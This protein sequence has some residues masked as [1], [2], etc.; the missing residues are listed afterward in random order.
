MHLNDRATPDLA[1]KK[2]YT[3][4]IDLIVDSITLTK[5]EIENGEVKTKLLCEYK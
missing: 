3:Y 2:S 5:I 1:F 4:T